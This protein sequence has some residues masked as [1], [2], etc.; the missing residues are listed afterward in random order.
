MFWAYGMAFVVWLLTLAHHA[1]PIVTHCQ[2]IG[3]CG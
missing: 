2:A 1:A 3:I